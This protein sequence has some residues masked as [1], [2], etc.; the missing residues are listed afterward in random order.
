MAGTSNSGG[1]NAKSQAMHVLQGTFRE[2]RHSQETAEPPLG[3]PDPPKPLVGD[4]RAEWD[5][6]L[7]RLETSRTLSIVDDAALF[8]YVQLFAE[9]EG[10][11]ADNLEAR[12]L[13]KELKKT[14]RDLEGA[15]LVQAVGEIV[16][17]YQIIAKQTDKL[18]Q[19]RMA[20]RQ[21]LVEFGMTPSAR[22]RVK[23]SGDPSKPANPL[24]KF[25]NRKRVNG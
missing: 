9:T 19:G 25:L 24:D 16:K 4:A 8:Q 5:R 10:I 20:V 17:L 11:K 23:A 21:Y 3:R 2:D 7:E 6:M 13:S 15:E 22:T 18:R 12:K 14:T 1:R